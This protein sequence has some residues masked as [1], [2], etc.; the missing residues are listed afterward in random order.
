ML[1]PNRY[2]VN[3]EDVG[4]GGALSHRTGSV[5]AKHMMRGTLMH[6]QEST[7]AAPLSARFL[8]N[9]HD[10]SGGNGTSSAVISPRG[11]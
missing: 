3:L 10:Y 6:P 11:P 2:E 7:S 8:E 5:K 4:A 1:V 9:N